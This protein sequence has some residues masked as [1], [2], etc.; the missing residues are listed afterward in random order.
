[1]AAQAG[2]NLICWLRNKPSGTRSVTRLA[3]Q[4]L[5]SVSAEGC[6]LGFRFPV[7]YSCGSVIVLPGEECAVK[8]ATASITT[9]R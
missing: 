5:E 2:N 6:A 4:S 8:A 1:M 7:G 3:C 9:I